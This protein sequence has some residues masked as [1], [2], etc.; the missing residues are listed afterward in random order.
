MIYTLHFSEDFNNSLN[1]NID[2][3]S[4]TLDNKI[5]AAS[6][7]KTIIRSIEDLKTFPYSCPLCE[8]PLYP[9]GIRKLVIKNYIILYWVN[10][11]EH[12]VDLMRFIYARADYLNKL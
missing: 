3:I 1:N 4:K 10:E 5:A 6:L 2:Y 12:S 8:E 9:D 11:A 7:M